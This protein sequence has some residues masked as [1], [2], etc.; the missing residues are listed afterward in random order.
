MP[1]P[2]CKPVYDSI[3]PKLYINIY[4]LKLYMAK[5]YMTKI[6]YLQCFIS[7][8]SLYPCRCAVFY[9]IS[10]CPSCCALFL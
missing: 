7:V 3:Y 1:K 2:V 4:G 5:P 10:C 8:G 6:V 9:L